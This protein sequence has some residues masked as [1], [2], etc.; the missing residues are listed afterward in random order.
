MN[1]IIE[2]DSGSDAD[3]TID[4]DDELSLDIVPLDETFEE[5]RSDRFM[6]IISVFILIHVICIGLCII[7]LLGQPL[8]MGDKEQLRIYSFIHIDYHL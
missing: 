2:T 6:R 3:I 1:D 8:E 4:L 7:A 5:K